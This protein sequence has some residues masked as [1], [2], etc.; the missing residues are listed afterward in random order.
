[1]NKI[2]HTIESD[3]RYH[4]DE[5]LIITPRPKSSWEKTKDI[6]FLAAAIAG[7][8]GIVIWLTE[9]EHRQTDRIIRKIQLASDGLKIIERAKLA[10]NDING[11]APSPE[12]LGLAILAIGRTIRDVSLPVANADINCGG[13]EFMNELTINGNKISFSDCNLFGEETIRIDPGYSKS[14]PFI[15]FKD[16]SIGPRTIALTNDDGYLHFRNSDLMW[17]KIFLHNYD[18][19]SIRFSNT[20]LDRVTVTRNTSG[21]G[22]GSSIVFRMPLIW[23]NDEYT[24]S[25][26]DHGC[27]LVEDQSRPRRPLR[28]YQC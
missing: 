17:T 2:D 3:S 27:K 26:P 15:E 6:I 24:F 25:W 12:E 18:E 20:N 14:T 16:T 21:R 4:A 7:I 8:A 23:K 22:G 9:Y 13:N 10:E 19:G 5:R 28:I 11:T 1:M